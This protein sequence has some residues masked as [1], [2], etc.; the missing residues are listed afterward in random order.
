MDADHLKSNRSPVLC[1]K[2][3]KYKAFMRHRSGWVGKK[4]AGYKYFRP[5]RPF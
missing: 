2:V 3:R 4:L 1:Q 5:N